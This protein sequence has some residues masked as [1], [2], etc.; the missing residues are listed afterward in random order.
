MKPFHVRYCLAPFVALL[1]AATAAADPVVAPVTDTPPSDEPAQSVDIRIFNDGDWSIFNRGPVRVSGYGLFGNFS[2]E[3]TLAILRSSEAHAVFDHTY[4]ED[5]AWVLIGRMRSDGYLEPRLDLELEHD[6]TPFFSASWD[7]DFTPPLPP[8]IEADKIIF[9]VH[10][11]VLFHYRNIHIDGITSI[12]PDDLTNY[13]YAAGFLFV[14]QSDRYYTPARLDSAV[15]NLL[16]TL[17]QKG[18]RRA[19]V[20]NQSVSINRETGDV[21]ITLEFEQGPL[22]YVRSVDPAP[23]TDD[24]PLLDEV[25]PLLPV[26][27]DQVYTQDWQLNLIAAIRKLYFLGGYPD[28]SIRLVPTSDDLDQDSANSRNI[29]TVDLALIIAPGDRVTVG[30][31]IFTG[32]GDTR[33]SVLER[34]LDYQSGDLLDVD[35]VRLGRD[36]LSSLGIFESVRV[37]YQE[38]DDNTRDVIYET[39]RVPEIQVSPIIGFGSFDIVRGGFEVDMTNLWGRAHRSR[40]RTIQSVRTTQADY[41]YRI[42]QVLGAN[43]SAYFSANYLDRQEISFER[44]E[45]G[46]TIGVSYYL[47]ESHINLAMQYNYQQLNSSQNNFDPAAGRASATATSIEWIASLSRL[48]NPIYPEHGYQLY[49]S[50]EVALP[51]LGGNVEYQRLSFGSSWHHPLRR[52]LIFHAGFRHGFIHTF[53]DVPDNIPFNKRFFLGGE[54]TVRGY[55]RG[56]ASPFDRSGNSIGSATFMLLNLQLEQKL[57]SLISASVFVDSIGIAREFSEYPFSTVLISAGV[58]LSINTIVGP[59]RLEYGQNLDPRPQDP[60]GTFQIAIGFPF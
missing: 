43:T 53:G 56:Q 60:D 30:E 10:P 33:Q 20:K 55:R 21:D 6:G 51:K 5:A 9:K 27:P 34:Q 52:S 57:S 37:R 48:D 58:G 17:R 47:P 39:A 44:R 31:I 41:L 28:L 3:R 59:I 4:I 35:K 49:T 45:Q 19:T 8:L 13:F 36:R 12:D 32:T 7:N 46:G 22:F 24:V 26:D 18:Y 15:D 14:S 23:G 2:L 16:Q 29:V 40:I 11:G 1:L 38:Q 25:L 42:P 50:L 54:N